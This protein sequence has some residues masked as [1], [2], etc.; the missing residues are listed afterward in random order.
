M[1]NASPTPL[2]RLPAQS[3][4]SRLPKAWAVIPPVPARRKPKFQ[5]SMS[6]ISD[7]TEIPPIK[8]AAEASR[9]PATA[10]STIPTSGTVRFA[11]MLG[12]A[13]R[14]ISLFIVSIRQR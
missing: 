7:P 3:S 10:M 1:M 12:R 9:C 13:R 4:R 11:I 2:A 8:A 6:N 14:S 5:Y